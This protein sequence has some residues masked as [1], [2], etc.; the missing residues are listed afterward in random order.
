M[1]LNHACLFNCVYTMNPSNGRIVFKAL[2]PIKKGQSILLIEAVLSS[3]A[4][5]GSLH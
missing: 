5:E 2:V 4:K 3:I 1:V